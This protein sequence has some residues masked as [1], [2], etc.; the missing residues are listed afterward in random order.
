MHV[1]CPR[2]Q[3]ERQPTLQGIII[4]NG[5]ARGVRP[6]HC[7]PAGIEKHGGRVLLRAHVD[8]VVMEGGR[9]AGVRLQPGK[10]GGRPELV[11]ARKGVISNAS[12]WDTVGL[13]E[14]GEASRFGARCGARCGVAPL[15]GP[16]WG[17]PLGQDACTA[18]LLAGWLAGWLGG[19]L[20][21]PLH[22]ECALGWGPAWHCWDGVG[23][24]CAL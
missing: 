19:W 10:K 16:F 2:D 7:T 20:A 24:G 4:C 14:P 3:R 8:R 21:L 6:A 18:C 13:L 22:R 12:V 17:T 15:G 23:C 1:A 5:L 11:K 9:A